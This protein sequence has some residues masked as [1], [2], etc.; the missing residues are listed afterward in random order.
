MWRRSWEKG[1][2]IDTASGHHRHKLGRYCF[3]LGPLKSEG[4]VGGPCKGP[5]T[6]RETCNRMQ[7]ETKRDREIKRQ[8]KREKEGEKEKQRR[9][10]KGEREKREREEGRKR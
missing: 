2:S 10:E 4:C 3:H 1:G 8:R 9:R 7:R 5:E 6:Y